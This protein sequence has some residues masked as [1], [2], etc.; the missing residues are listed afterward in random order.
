MNFSYW[1]LDQT[2]DFEMLS[3]FGQKN[4]YDYLLTNAVLREVDLALL[5]SDNEPG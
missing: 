3:I 5:D 1:S 4:L 2:S